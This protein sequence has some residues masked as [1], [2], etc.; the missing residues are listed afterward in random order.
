MI[1]LVLTFLLFL[2]VVVLVVNVTVLLL[3]LLFYPYYPPPGYPPHLPNNMTSVVQEAGITTWLTRVSRSVFKGTLSLKQKYSKDI[4]LLITVKHFVSSP[5]QI[6]D[7]WLTSWAYARVKL[8][9]QMQ[10]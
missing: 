10:F 2:F 8:H 4:T 5:L 6:G 7:T 1:M 9:S 3:L